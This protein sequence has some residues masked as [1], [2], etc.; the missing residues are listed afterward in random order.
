MHS[1]GR[2]ALTKGRL[3]LPDEVVAGQALLIE[4]DKI[5]GI[6]GAGALPT[7]V[8]QVDVGGRLVCPGLIDIHIHGALG[9]NFNERSEAAYAAIAGENVRQGVTSLLATLI[10]ASLPDLVDTLNFGRRWM[11]EPRPGARLLGMYLEGPYISPAQAGALDPRHLGLPDDGTLPILLAHHDVVSIMALAP[12]LPGALGLIDQLVRVG[13][14]PAAGHSSGRDVHLAAAMEHGLRHIH[15]IWSGQSSMVREGPWR[16]PGLVEASLAFEGLTVEM[17]SNNKH[18]PATLMKLAYKCIG[19]DR[20]CAITDA[21]AGAGLPE[22]AHFTMGGVE[23]DVSDGV[24]MMLDRSGFAGSTIL[25][26]RMVPVL[27]DVVGVPLAAALRMV[28]L[29]PARAIGWQERKGSLEAGKDADVAVFEDD[30]SVWRTMVGGQWVFAAT[31][32]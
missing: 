12:E 21:T 8:E 1:P 13:I 3:S 18:L 15:H 4:G 32:L 23:F 11:Q 6:T 22:G 20:L 16:R 31:G 28:T 14:I 17:I 26:N 24:S 2:F 9:R 29:T 5:L 25:L 30:F 19:P 7:D 10:T 27:T